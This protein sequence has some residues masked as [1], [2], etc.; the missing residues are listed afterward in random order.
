MDLRFATVLATALVFPGAVRAQ[1]A[2]TMPRDRPA[3]RA[4][5]TASIKGRIV[6][7]VTGA[8][9]PRARVRLIGGGGSRTAV[10]TDLAGVFAFTKLPGSAGGC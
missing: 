4:D 9:V 7:G 5:G 8:A 2:P 3:V 6:D 1:P 10:M